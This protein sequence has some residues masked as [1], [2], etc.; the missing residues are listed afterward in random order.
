[1]YSGEFIKDVKS[2]T[3]MMKITTTVTTVGGVAVG[4]VLRFPLTV[5]I[6]ELYKLGDIDSIVLK[7][8][9]RLCEVPRQGP[10]CDLRTDSSGVGAERGWVTAVS[11][12]HP[13]GLCGPLGAEGPSW[14]LEGKRRRAPVETPG[15]GGTA[16]PGSF[17]QGGPFWFYP[18]P[19]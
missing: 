17:H 6:E 9:L 16:E 7:R 11:S 15:P 1:M 14:S 18:V 2:E 3:K 19:S 5:L 8:R 13:A 10:G 4:G 12:V